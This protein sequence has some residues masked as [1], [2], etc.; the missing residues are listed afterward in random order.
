MKTI[1]T[2]DRA[3]QPYG[4]PQLNQN[5]H[6]NDIISDGNV[7]GMSI[8][9]D[10]TT[11]YTHGVISQNGTPILQTVGDSNIFVGSNSGGFN[12]ISSGNTAIGNSS[13]Q[14]LPSY[15]KYD[16]FNGTTLTALTLTYSGLTN[17]DLDLI[18]YLSLI[19]I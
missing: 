9:I 2:L 8:N 18:Q 10:T 6:F 17:N 19:H 14:V 11:G 7:S 5:S 16:Y 4:Y 12:N 3:N 15:P 1:I 13:L